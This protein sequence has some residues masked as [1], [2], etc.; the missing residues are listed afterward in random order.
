M[1]MTVNDSVDLSAVR[2]VALAVRGGNGVFEAAP[3]HDGHPVLIDYRTAIGIGAIA[4]HSLFRGLGYRTAL[5]TAVTG[6][7]IW[8]G[9]ATTCPIPDQSTGEQMTV[10]STHANDTSAGANVR[11]IHVHY[12]DVNGN[13]QTEEITMNGTTEVDTTATNIRFIQYI[14][15]TEIGTFGGVAAGDITIHKKGFAATVYT[16]IKAGGNMSLNTSRMVPI[17]K[18]FYMDNITISGTSSKPLS[19]RIR[20]TRSE[21]GILTPGIFLFNEIFSSQDSGIHINISIPRIFPALTIIKASVYSLQA[22]G[23]AT[24]SYSGWLE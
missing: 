17:N 3:G 8:Q 19:A 18:S 10:K 15:T 21:E 6:D 5:S 4:G 24:V 22:G 13:E 23:E 20:A 16:M 11:K 14:H 1:S 2:Y 7:D 9:T 12:I